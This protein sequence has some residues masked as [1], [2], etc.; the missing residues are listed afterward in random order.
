MDI[1]NVERM[2]IHELNK[3]VDKL[4]HANATL[5]YYYVK[6]DKDLSNGLRELST[7]QHIN[8]FYK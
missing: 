5:M 3:M 2:S 7:Y 4:G 1:C 8:M 6:L